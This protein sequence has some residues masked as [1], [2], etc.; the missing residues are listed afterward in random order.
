MTRSEKAFA[1]FVVVMLA[2]SALGA[3]LMVL[4]SR[5]IDTIPVQ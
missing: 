2:L 3:A 4:T 5:H 1:W